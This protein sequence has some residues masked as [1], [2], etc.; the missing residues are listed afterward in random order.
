M[1]RQSDMAMMAAGDEIA[2]EGARIFQLFKGKNFHSSPVNGCIGLLN[3]PSQLSL[4]FFRP[5]VSISI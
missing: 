4:A 2:G 3:N 1:I 5:A